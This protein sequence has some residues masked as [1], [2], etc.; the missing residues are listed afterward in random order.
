MAGPM[1]QQGIPPD[2]SAAQH[3]FQAAYSAFNQNGF[4]SAGAPPTSNMAEP[5]LQQ[6]IPPNFSA[7]QL[8]PTQ[9]VRFKHWQAP[10]PSTGAATN[11]APTMQPVAS[12][13]STPPAVNPAPPA[14]T[15]SLTSPTFVCGWGPVPC[16]RSIR[17]SNVKAHLTRYHGMKSK[18][19]DMPTLC[20]DALSHLFGL[21]G[22]WSAVY[23][24]RCG[25][26]AY[27]AQPVDLQGCET[28]PD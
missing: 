17:K 3:A 9:G 23:E 18:L 16:G 10:A 22:V 6:G 1:L 12:T 21:F 25:E 8:Q 11:N 13:S 24:A 19:Q 4:T 5:M 26:E 15:S 7:P 27:C 28:D 20:Y 2:F 14:S